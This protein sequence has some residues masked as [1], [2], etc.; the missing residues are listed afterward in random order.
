MGRR[1]SRALLVLISAETLLAVGLAAGAAWPG[2]DCAAAE[3]ARRS[4]R[5]LVSALDLTDLALFPGASYTRH[6]SQADLFAPF[7]DHPAALERSPAGSVVPAPRPPEIG[8][9]VRRPGRRP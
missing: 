9:A 8:P 1:L 3:A 7:S 4:N 5:G 2:G 6:P